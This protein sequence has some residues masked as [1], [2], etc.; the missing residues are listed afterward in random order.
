MELSALVLRASRNPPFFLWQDRKQNFKYF[1]TILS[2][3]TFEF[4]HVQWESGVEG[5]T[6]LTFY[7]RLPKGHAPAILRL[8]S[9]GWK[10]R[11]HISEK[12]MKMGVS[13]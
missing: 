7:V 1:F 9:R 2:R 12:R 4:C 5:I 6:G 11:L 10:G 3:V 8:K 13:G